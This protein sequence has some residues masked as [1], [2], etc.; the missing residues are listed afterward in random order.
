MAPKCCANVPVSCLNTNT[1]LTESDVAAR[2]R[3]AL[4]LGLSGSPATIAR[5]RRDGGGV[6]ET[7]SLSLM[8]R[9]IIV[10]DQERVCSHPNNE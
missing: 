7:S 1:L 4:I 10:T 9:S 8:E 3:P 2:P 5:G 6:T